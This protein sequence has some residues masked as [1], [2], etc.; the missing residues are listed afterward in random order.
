MKLIRLIAITAI[1]VLLTGCNWPLGSKVE[2]PPAH[3]G[4]VLT[5]A[6]FSD[7]LKHPSK[8]RLPA[9]V[10]WCDKLVLLEVSDNSIK[11]SFKIFMP[12][13][14]MYLEIE[15]RGTFSIPAIPQ[16][17]DPLFARMTA[18]DTNDG[19]VMMIS[20]RRVYETYGAQAV[21]GIVRSGIA[22]YDIAQILQSREE[23]GANIH[24]LISAKLKATSTPIQLTRFELADIKPPKVI[25]DAQEAA[26]KREIEI[27]QAE[28]DAQVKMVEAQR[29]LDV[30]KLQRMVDRE[31]AQAIAEQNKIAA[32]SITPQLLEYRRLESAERIFTAIA[33]SDNS[34]VIPLDSSSFNSFGE[35]AAF[36]DTLAKK[37]KGSK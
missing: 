22:G 1:A 29:A 32:Q 30:A 15:V 37:L 9:C 11:E 34:L 36:A 21:R 17:I 8:F 2:V 4:K 27:Q 24:S 28:A 19:D 5:Q 23:V 33:Q 26:K 31:K 35:S 16:Y 10:A 3:V 18:A 25:T 7:D 6:G 20:A 12:N 14:E 13:D